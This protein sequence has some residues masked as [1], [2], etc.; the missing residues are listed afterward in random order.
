[1]LV[2]VQGSARYRWRHRCGW[3]KPCPKRSKAGWHCLSRHSRVVWPPV[4]PSAPPVQ[5]LRH[6][7]SALDCDHRRGA[8]QCG[9][10]RSHFSSRPAPRRRWPSRS[11]LT[12]RRY[13]RLQA[14]EPAL[15]DLA[16][17]ATGCLDGRHSGLNR[18]NAARSIR[19][20]RRLAGGSA[21]LKP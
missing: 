3:P 16:R 19:E 18:G 20:R 7:W 2:W 6:R 15:S 21:N 4:R 14:A 1:V 10:R 17:S 9:G 13:F 8:G 12:E 5:H 11:V